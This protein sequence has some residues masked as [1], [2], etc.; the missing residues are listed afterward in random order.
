MP[1]SSCAGLHLCLSMACSCAGMACKTLALAARLT[2]TQL[3]E[4]LG[5]P[6]PGTCRVVQ[7]WP[8]WQYSSVRPAAT[9]PYSW[10]H[11]DSLPSQLVTDPCSLK[12]RVRLAADC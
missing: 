1:C 5:D 2:F 6:C 8:A 7:Q 12:V 3:E 10:G 9:C 11:C 4:L